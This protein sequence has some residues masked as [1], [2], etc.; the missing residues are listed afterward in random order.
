M[1]RAVVPLQ[2]D[3]FVGRSL[4]EVTSYREDMD[5]MSLPF[6]SLEKTPRR[7]P[8]E[9]ERQQ[10]DRRIYVRVSPGEYGLA[11]IWDN[12]VL[13]YLRSQILLALNK[14]EDV[15][16]RI[17]FRI[18]DCLR[19]TGRHTGNKDY[20]L[21]DAALKRLKTTTV[22]TNI[23]DTDE[24]EDQGFGWI[25]SYKIRRRKN[26][27]GA[28]IMAACEVVISEWLY[29]MFVA[30]DRSLAMDPKYF[31]LNGG[32]ERKLYGIVRKHV[33]RQQKWTI[34]VENLRELCGVKREVRKFRYD[35]SKIAE[36]GLPG[37]TLTLTK[38][39]RA[40]NPMLAALPEDLANPGR[41]GRKEYL[42]C[43]P[44]RQQLLHA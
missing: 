33:G 30:P 16:R 29:A 15:S 44:A 23:T 10:G 13:I 3:L 21:F 17:S 8:L 41:R 11:T 39:P 40:A 32:L 38:D 18:Y 9:Y 2:Q 35:L 5:I 4:H 26:A 6:F 25:E 31:Q 28:D 20:E 22:F 12:D 43:Q 14:G 36:R 19:A 1:N 34:T 37:F 24:T 27:S 42:V 7:E